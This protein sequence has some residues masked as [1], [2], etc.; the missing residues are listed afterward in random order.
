MNKPV[1]L[2]LL[3]VCIG[4][5]SKPAPQPTPANEHSVVV[6]PAEAEARIAA[7]EKRLADLE[8]KSHDHKSGV[9]DVPDVPEEKLEADLEA[10]KSDIDRLNHNFN[11]VKGVDEHNI[12]QLFWRTRCMKQRDKGFEPI[13]AQSSHGHEEELPCP[14]EHKEPAKCSKCD[15]YG[16]RI[17][18]GEK[19]PCGECWQTG[20]AE[21]PKAYEVQRT[22]TRQK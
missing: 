16:Y 7:I 17:E 22:Q 9:P 12:Q 3:L 2:L 20:M 18:H 6:L 1:C 10:L 21:D 4:C 8:A 19:V 5:D 14:P 15:G 11:V 13:K